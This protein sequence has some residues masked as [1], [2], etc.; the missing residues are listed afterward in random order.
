MARDLV[1]R[2]QENV[3]LR[4]AKTCFRGSLIVSKSNERLSEMKTRKQLFLDL[5]S[6]MLLKGSFKEL[7]RLKPDW[8]WIQERMG[9]KE[10][11]IA[12]YNSLVLV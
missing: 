8:E 1:G 2:C 11:D 10:M 3:M 9:N 12:N 4:K 5:A 6:L 7:V